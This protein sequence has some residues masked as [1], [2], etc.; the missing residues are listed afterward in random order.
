MFEMATPL[1]KCAKEVRSVILFFWS[2]D[3]KNGESCG[4]MTI[5][6]GHNYTSQKEV[7]EWVEG[8][9][10]GRTNIDGA[11]SGSSTVICVEVKEQFDQRIRDN[12]RI[13][14]D[15]TV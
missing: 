8:F 6:S 3:I 4:G 15:E 9:K 1:I 2:E 7:Y 14:I 13:P 5:Q 12:R 11:C 10:E